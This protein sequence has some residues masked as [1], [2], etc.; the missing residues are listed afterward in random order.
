MALCDTTDFRTR[1]ATRST[2]DDDQIIIVRVEIVISSVQIVMFACRWIE[3]SIDTT[4]T[5]CF[6]CVIT[7]TYVHDL[8]GISDEDEEDWPMCCCL[9][10]M[11]GTVSC[12]VRS[13]NC[14]SINGP[15]SEERQTR[16]ANRQRTNERK[17]ERTCS[18][19]WSNSR[20]WNS[21]LADLNASLI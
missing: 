18:P 5:H 17:K 8:I 11:F 16:M 4:I 7:S 14:S 10:K 2:S 15:C 9:M 21:I 6:K 3:K 12:F 13:I 1:Q 20:Q 19:V